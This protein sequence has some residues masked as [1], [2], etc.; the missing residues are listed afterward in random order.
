MAVPLSAGLLHRRQFEEAWVLGIVIERYVRSAAIL[1]DLTRPSG[2]VAG[3]A[4]STT[5]KGKTLSAAPKRRVG[6]SPVLSCSLPVNSLFA[7]CKFPVTLLHEKRIESRIAD[8]H[9]LSK[10]I[11]E[12]YPTKFAKFPCI[13]PCYREFAPETGSHQ[14][15]STARQSAPRY[16]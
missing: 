6:D 5:A 11:R 4:Q 14:T 13:F 9:W 3:A 15:A 2:L 7:P 8:E 12:S 1:A 10:R 16:S